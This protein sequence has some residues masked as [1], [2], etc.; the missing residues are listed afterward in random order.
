MVWNV[1]D[2]IN[3]FGEDNG[4]MP[5][6][7]SEPTQA[8]CGSEEKIQVMRE[9]VDAGEELWHPEDSIIQDSSSLP[10]SHSF[11]EK[12]GKAAQKLIYRV[13]FNRDFDY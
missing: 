13:V 5:L 10:Q 6:P 1:Y 2:T 7:A 12:K 11:F 8:L 4:F 9:R 3:R